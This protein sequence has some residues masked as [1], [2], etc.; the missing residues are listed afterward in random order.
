MEHCNGDNIIETPE[1]PLE[2]IVYILS[3]LHPSDRREASLVC[4][5]WYNASQD[6]SFQKNVTFSFPAS[7]SSLE[8]I[9]G[10]GRKSRCS[11]II[12]Q[13]DGHSLSKSLLQEV[14]LCVGSKLESLALPGSSITEAS[15]LDLLPRLTSLRRLDLRGLDS[16]F[17]SGTFLSREEHRQQV[18]SALSGL[19]ELDLSDLRYLSDLTFNRLTGCT[20]RLR[21]LSLAGCHIAFEFDPYHG[22][23]VGA[24]EDSSALLSLRNLRKLLM[25]QKSTLVALD[26][27]RTSITPESL[28]T[29]AQVQGLVLEELCLHGCKELTDYSMEVLVKHQPSLQRLDISACKELTNR[30]VEATAQGLKSLTHLSLS[31]DWRITEKG[32]AEL[33]SVSSLRSL[34][35][36][37]CL[38]ISG[39]EIVRGLTESRTARAHLETLS[40]KSC[41]YIRDLAVFSLT[42]LLRDSLHELDLTSCVNVTDLSVRA[43]A[44]YL[45]RL[46]VLRLGYCKEVTDWGLLGIEETAKCEHDQ[47][48]GDKGPKFTRTFGNMGFFKPPRLPFEERPKL[49]TNN[50]LEQFKQQAGASLLAL[51]RLQELDLSACPKLTDSSIT[52]VVHYPDLHRLSLSMLTEITDASLASVA[53]HCRSLTS[54]ALSHCPGISDRGVAQAAPYLCRLQHL[55]LS[56]CDNITDRSL[57]LLMQHCKRLRTLDISRCKNISVTT[58]DLLQSQLP[59]LENINY[60]FIGGTDLTL[61][62]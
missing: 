46:V 16:L 12:S 35:L 18:R 28:R 21:R 8:L 44:T 13:L 56:C 51:S 60:K 15:L 25:E 61:T 52:Q 55:Y 41:T 27:S 58:V 10:L 45:H 53:W 36:S 48:S 57:F 59:F 49:V 19:E 31:R 1:L 26:L 5:S 30:S 42:Q 32:L 20:P 43:I 23:P 2:I 39:T 17:M 54:L 11:L 4:R 38:H 37:E 47:D 7:A 50:D 3:F 62:L 6:F 14:G 34:D 22:C 24:V 33:L 40:L 9:R 29:I